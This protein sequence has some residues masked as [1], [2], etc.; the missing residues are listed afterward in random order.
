MLAYA[1]RAAARRG[2]GNAAWVRERAEALPANLGSFRVVTFAQSFHW[3]DRPR[4]AAAVATMLDPGGAV[5]H[6]DSRTGEVPAEARRAPFPS[7]PGE[8]LDQLRRQY[9]GSDRRAGQGIRNTSPSGED[10]VFQQAGFMPAETVTVPDRRV[11]KRT[12]DDLVANVF[13]SSSTAPHL[14]GDRQED[15]EADLRKILAQASPHGRFSVR[16]PDNILRIWRLPT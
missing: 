16:L 4:V 1:Y 7:P 9:L 11:V 13:S 15:F 8:A 12:I 3:M 2:I 14:L 5:V 10:E 6:I